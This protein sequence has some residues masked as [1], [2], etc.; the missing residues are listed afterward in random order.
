MF[1][2]IVS[3]RGIEASPSQVTALRV[4]TVP[5]TKD[6]LRSFLGAAGYLWRFLPYYA[7]LL[8]PLT[9]LMRK[10]VVFQCDNVEQRA[11]QRVKDEPCDTVLLAAPKGP[12]EFVI[13]CDASDKSIGAVPMQLQT[14]SIVIIEFASHSLSETEYAVKWARERFRD[15]VRGVKVF[16]VAAHESLQGMEASD[17]GK[18]QRWM[19]YIQQFDAQ[20]VL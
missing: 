8:Q 4:A 10:N 2:S 5:K 13:A 18:L 15:Y 9:N 6:E 16:V 20:I 17:Q 14:G 3:E 1:G 19:L 11:F 12:G 7:Q